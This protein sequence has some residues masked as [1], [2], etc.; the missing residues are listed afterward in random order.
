MAVA[1]ATAV[2]AAL[3]A[4][5]ALPAAAA[6]Q[7]PRL[8]E[9]ARALAAAK[10]SGKR[11]EVTGE[12]T[13]RTTV[14]ANPDG[15]TF[16]L[17]ES[18]V[19]VRVAGPDGGWRTPDAT[20]ER[21]ADGTV[22]PRAS[23]AEMAFS[24][25]GDKAPL[26][27]IADKGRM[28]ALD[29]PGRLPE[30]RLEGASAL[31]R[32][33]LPDVD[34]RVTA[35]VEGFQHVLVV[36]TPEG[37]ARPELKELTF[38]LRT[39]GGLTVRKNARGALAA[40]DATGKT[41]F[42]APTAQMWNSAGKAAQE[43][44][45]EAGVTPTRPQP[46]PA[47]KTPVNEADIPRA[48]PTPA[49]PPVPSQGSAKVTAP[50]SAAPVKAAEAPS[51]ATGLEPGQ[52]DEVAR[53]GVKVTKSA[54]S[55]VPDA[56]LLARTPAAA[57]PVYI[58]PT[59]TWGE[60][61]RTLLRSD[62]YESYGWGNGD[63]GL[64]KGV[65]KCGTW[66]GYYCGPGYVQRLYFEFSP[67]SL[68]GK[69]VLDATFR[70]TEPWAFQCSPRWV[71][72]VRT[73]NI[74][75]STTW[76]TRPKELDW[77][78]DRHVSAGRGSLCDP[79]SPDAPIEFN[80][81]P[82]ETNEN[83]TPTVRDFAAGKF[84]RLTL[85]IRAHDETDTSAWKRFK[86]DAVLAVD[87]VGLPEKPSSIGLVTGSGTT[88]STTESN[89]SIVSDPTPAL[90]A[91]A[92]TKSGGENGAQLRVA[93]DIDHKNTDGTWGDTTAGAGD[94]RPSTGYIGDNAKVT[95]SWSSLTEGKLYRYRAWVRSY[96]NNGGS[97]LSGPSN[98]STTGWCYFK[99]DPTAPKAP[100]ITFGTPYTE[101]TTNAC[102]AKGGPGVK[103]TW[104]F[105]PATGDTTNVSYQYNLSSTSTFPTATGSAPT[106][107]ITPERSGTYTL[108][109]RAKDNVG[110]YGA[111]NA[112]DFLVAAGAGSVA[113]YHFDEA[114]G[115]AVDS[116]TTGTTRHPA[117]LAAGAV[118]DDRGRRGLI[119]HDAA[120]Q[121][122]ATQVTDKGLRLDGSTGWASTS[123]PVLETRSS[124]TVSAWAWVDP[125]SSKTETILSH[126]PSTASPWAKKYS[127]FI[128]SYKGGAWSLRVFSTE[129][130]F[131]RDAS[132]PASPKG[133]WTHVAGVHDATAKKVH[134]YING[135]LQASVDAGTP[136]SADGNLEIGRVMYG[137]T[138]VD[139]F[140][141]SIDE[142]AVWQRALTAKEIADE[143]RTLISAG[144]SG[145]EL[146]ADWRAA[147]GS[148][149]T[150][151]DTTSG[152]GK[153]LTL[154]GGA[155][156]VDGEIVLDGVDDGAMSPV[157]TAVV[158]GTGAFTLTTTV[159]LDGA[160]L[161]SKP[162]GYAGRVLGQRTSGSG[163][164]GFWYEVTGKETVLDEETLEERTVPVGKWH[165][166]ARNADG[167]YTSVVS[168]EVAALDSPVRLTGVFDPLSATMRLYLGHNQN[169]DDTEYTAP[170]G[171]SYEVSA[172]R[173]WNGSAWFEHLPARIGEVR[174]FSGAV[175]GPEQIA[176]HIGD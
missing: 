10:E 27:S 101:C 41:V 137:D 25:G 149:T 144:Y 125:A 129:G 86:N 80:D 76:S 119:T 46:T 133:T 2:L 126:T 170:I 165:F 17:E 84:S 74:S 159:S 128:V 70:V 16:T 22:G 91:T 9:G 83:L 26:V 171:L 162:V 147:D 104:T 55:V 71:D 14:H 117:T 81:N 148:G 107:T 50:S 138:Y 131:S 75:S 142:V 38:G 58:D 72:L 62:G 114:S 92:Q 140:Q 94:V 167:T 18:A 118:R 66:N 106:V 54:L 163:S 77:M 1:T 35:T 112:V 68:K 59:V 158:D 136:W 56:S 82:E 174:L 44:R 121:P 124:Y 20:L 152:Y 151:A 36:K 30:P 64:G 90:T 28:L 111:W 52:G 169:G 65:G 53:M 110:R 4:V 168:D 48:R 39:A 23:A 135:T 57:F 176:S 51:S 89:P 42:R 166:G 21:R 146:V 141:G 79:D 116:A 105:K 8:S 87:F 102:A 7:S 29:W 113:R 95:M 156:V 60:S 49:G 47:V 145:L 172:G 100:V 67:A 173:A 99:V 3:P 40:L 93:F 132:A 69:H 19:P 154:S 108:W 120:G 103:G 5:G 45:L 31:Y 175:A 98:G 37:A 155:S 97:Y 73:N 88:C 85:Q 43:R 12:R 32:D 78:G 13:E 127:P 63:D 122:L 130:T 61:E 139:Q 34:L 164:Y 96:Y 150:V 161:A 153:T 115:V 134:L 109:V 33:V 157:N 11:V 160:K 143:A 6:E 24:G 15:L 123:G